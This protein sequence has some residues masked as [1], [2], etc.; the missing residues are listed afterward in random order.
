[1]YVGPINIVDLNPGQLDTGQLDTGQL[2]TQE[3]GKIG[4]LHTC[5]LDTCMTY[6]RS[7]Q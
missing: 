2:D 7:K 6:F 3:S 4:Q 1:M 5:I